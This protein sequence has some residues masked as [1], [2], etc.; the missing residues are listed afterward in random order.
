MKRPGDA[1]RR[2]SAGQDFAER[3]QVGMN[4]VVGLSAAGCN[5]ECR[6]YFIDN[7]QTA[8]LITQ[9]T[10]FGQYRWWLGN[11][12]EMTTIGLHDDRGDVVMLIERLVQ[13]GRI[14]RGH[15]DDVLCDRGQEAPHWRT[16]EVGRVPGT[17][18]IVPAVI[19]TAEAND[20]RS[21]GIGPGEPDC[22][23]CCFGS[24]SGEPDFVGHGQ[25][26]GDTPC[27]FRLAGMTGGELAALAQGGGGSCQH[28]RMP[29]A[30]H[31]RSMAAE[32][33]QVLIVVHIELSGAVG[34][35]KNGA[36][37][38]EKAR[39]CGHTARQNLFGRSVDPR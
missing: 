4:P 22:Q 37:G 23:Q 3:G 15:Q 32:K 29:V 31:Q 14:S 12:A 24:G 25:H 10:H 5:T 38:F 11:R 16:I 27:P 8:M 20:L 7:Q 28:I 13:P 35:L 2:E 21:A 34:A 36:V 19:V 39:V 33:I 6:N 30:Q 17:R 18:V 26:V 1:A 9:R